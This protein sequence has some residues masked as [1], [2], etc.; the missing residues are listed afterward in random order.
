MICSR[1]SWSPTNFFLALL[2]TK[3]KTWP[4]KNNKQQNT[5]FCISS[6]ATKPS[7]KATKA[8]TPKPAPRP[9]SFC[10]EYTG[11]KGPT[12]VYWTRSMIPCKHARLDEYLDWIKYT[13]SK[14]YI[15]RKIRCG[16]MSPPRCCIKFNCPYGGFDCTDN[17]SKYE[18][19]GFYFCPDTFHVFSDEE[20]SKE[21]KRY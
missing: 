5:T 9:V 16:R 4:S 18:V 17:W 6:K 1:K 10:I 2:L 14:E 13:H 7:T 3:S 20:G 21:N 11:G 8:S 19:D 12:F 15:G